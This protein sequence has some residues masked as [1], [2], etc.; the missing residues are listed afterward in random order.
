MTIH[1][2]QGAADW[3]PRVLPYAR[4]SVN[5]SK[6]CDSGTFAHHSDRRFI[7]SQ[8]H[9][10]G[11]GVFIVSICLA[12]ALL[13]FR[14]S[15]APIVLHADGGPLPRRPALGACSLPPG[16]LR[17]QTS[18]SKSHAPQAGPGGVR[19]VP[20]GAARAVCQFLFRCHRR[21]QRCGLA[22]FRCLFRLHRC[23]PAMPA[24]IWSRPSARH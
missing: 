2:R 3:L 15:L 19:G 12:G 6:R 5:V 22:A 20:G 13:A 7:W 9:C 16:P 10:L 1:C 17:R 4:R 24:N 18:P 8:V 14:D 11:A 21:R 23:S